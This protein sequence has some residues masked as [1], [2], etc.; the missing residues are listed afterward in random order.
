MSNHAVTALSFRA[1]NAAGL[2]ASL[3][4]ARRRT[5]A[6]L[7]IFEDTGCIASNRTNSSPNVSILWE[8]G[9]LAWFAEWCVL[10]EASA[11]P[12]FAAKG[13]SLLT[14]GDQWFGQASQ[15]DMDIQAHELPS[16]GA[17]NTYC[18]EVYDRVQDKLTYS[19]RLTNLDAFRIALL[20]EDLLGEAW[21]AR[22]Q[23]RG[24]V[25]GSQWRDFQLRVHGKG[26]I[27]MPEGEHLLGS[28]NDGNFVPD[29]EK[30]QH[31]RQ[32]QAF[33]IDTALVT[34]EDYEKFVRDGGYIARQWWSAAGWAEIVGAGRR[35]PLAW[36]IEDASILEFRF[37]HWRELVP[38]EPVRHVSLHEALAYCAWA[39]RRLPTELEWEVA[40][41]SGNNAFRWG[42]L[43]EWTANAFMPYPGFRPDVWS[44]YSTSAFGTH[45]VL[46]GASWATPI[47]LR[48]SKMRA[49]SLPESGEGF[50]GFRTCP[51]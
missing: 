13:A 35:A 37:G 45:H 1:M 43:W 44:D 21:L 5:L 18:R 47:R 9:R 2:A 27:M 17:M 40:A 36:Q 10:R 20:Y 39:G 48:S 26:S 24:I 31:P 28:A 14:L 16:L 38:E 3:E 34:N 12:P 8:Y 30:W 32:H 25:P 19:T 11:M 33:A 6:L 46:R 23:A 50:V 29:N 15:A 49:F 41:V 7:R 42:D 51:A 22:M 4:E